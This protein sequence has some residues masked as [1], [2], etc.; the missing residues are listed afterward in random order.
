MVLSCMQVEEYTCVSPS[1]ATWVTQ[2]ISTVP[3]TIF[4]PYW[5]V[6][7][8]RKISTAV[9]RCNY[10]THKSVIHPIMKNE[11]KICRNFIARAPPN[12]NIACLTL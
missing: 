8:E 1:V 5:Y 4:R 2:C 9:I 12:A 3:F 10:F 11:E 6:L 7:M